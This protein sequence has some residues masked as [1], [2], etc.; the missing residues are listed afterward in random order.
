MKFLFSTVLLICLS[1]GLTAPRS[2]EAQ[3]LVMG[4]SVLT[5]NNW[6]REGSVPEIL[7]N[8]YGFRVVDRA[9]PGSG[10]FKG[11]N[12]G[13]SVPNQFKPGAWRAVVINGGANDLL[14]F[15]G[16]KVCDEV[17]DRLITTDGKSGSYA[18]LLNRIDGPVILVGYYGLI[19]GGG[20]SAYDACADETAELA[21]RLKSVADKDTDIHFI[22]LRRAFNG[23]RKYYH[24]DFTHPSQAGTNLIA[25]LVVDKLREIRR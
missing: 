25:K 12:G 19:R 13:A 18:D 22:S 4:D 3:V 15:C 14:S 9:V 5:W 21:R 1:I 16:C 6:T 11:H 23:N 20:G 8:R 17:L 7:Q 2:A 24:T 10:F